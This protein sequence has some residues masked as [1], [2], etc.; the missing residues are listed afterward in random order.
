VQA[1]D[2]IAFDCEI[3]TTELAI[4]NNATKNTRCLMESIIYEFY[5]FGYGVKK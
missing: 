1:P 5:Y 3:G 2:P 4:A